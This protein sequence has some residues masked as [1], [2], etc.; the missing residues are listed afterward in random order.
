MSATQVEGKTILKTLF[1]A[2]QDGKSRYWYPIGRLTFDGEMYKFVYTQ[3][4]L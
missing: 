1:L 3:G 2:W 4:M